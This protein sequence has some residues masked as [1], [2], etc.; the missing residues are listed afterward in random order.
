MKKTI[1]D[2]F[3]TQ[4]DLEQAM[5]DWVKKNRPKA[6]KFKEGDKVKLSSLMAIGWAQRVTELCGEIITI[7][8]VSEDVTFTHGEYE[9]REYLP[10]EEWKINFSVSLVGYP[11]HYWMEEDFTEI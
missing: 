11:G 2:M 3:T 10:K 4:A 7:D 5:Y 9:D 1:A 8:K 6:P